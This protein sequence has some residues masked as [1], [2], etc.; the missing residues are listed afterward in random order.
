MSWLQTFAF[1]PR[2]PDARPMRVVDREIVD[3]LEFHLDMRTLENVGAGMSAD[4]ARQDALRRFGDF[5]RIH[6]TCRQTLLGERI[7]LQR[8]QAILTLVLL[9]A[10]IFMGVALY[11]GQSANETATAQIME[12]LDKITT[13]GSPKLTSSAA[14]EYLA[15][16]T[17]YPAVF[18]FQSRTT[19]RAAHILNQALYPEFTHHFT[20]RSHSL[21]DYQEQFAKWAKPGDTVILLLLVNERDS[22]P[23]EFQDLLPKPWPEVEAEV[24]RSGA[25]RF[26]GESRK[27]HVVLLVANSEAGLTNLVQ[28]IQW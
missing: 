12:K 9:V 10:I 15:R 27:M 7:M 3:E 16:P 2:P 22:I 28:K 11:R 20:G 19:N 18:V 5:E 4:E 24:T 8:L 21:K 13:A 14:I 1:V 6:K 25:A 17:K 26:D 23:A